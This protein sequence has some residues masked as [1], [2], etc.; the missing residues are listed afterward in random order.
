MYDC[1]V[2]YVSGCCGFV[3]LY[4]RDYYLGTG[5]PCEEVYSGPP[6]NTPREAADDAV[7]WLEANNIKKYMGPILSGMIGG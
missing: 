3:N 2:N 6:R 4:L 7:A 1:G 5:G